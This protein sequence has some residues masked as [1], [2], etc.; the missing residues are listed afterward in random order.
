MKSSIRR[1]SGAESNA[2]CV[3]I[4]VDRTPFTQM[5]PGDLD[6]AFPVGMIG[7]IESY[8]SAAETPA[9]FRMTGRSCAT[10]VAWTKMK[11]SQP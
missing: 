9:E 6:G 11:L 3:N 1:T 2:G 4:F 5:T 10:I 7:A 8:A